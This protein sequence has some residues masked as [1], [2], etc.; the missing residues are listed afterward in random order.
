MAKKMRTMMMAYMTLT[1]SALMLVGGSYALFTDEVNEGVHLQAGTLD[2]GLKRTSLTTYTLDPTTGKTLKTEKTNE[3][4]FTNST[5]NVFGLTADTK[6]VPG[7]TFEATMKLE[8]VDA[9]A[10][11]YWISIELAEKDANGTAIDYGTLHLDDQ[12]A[13]TV[14]VSDEYKIEGR[15]LGNG[16]FTLGS[17][18]DTIGTIEKDGSQTFTVKVEFL[19][20]GDG[21]NNSSMGETIDFDLVVYAVQNTEILETSSSNVNA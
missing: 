20:L 7:N 21:E 5:E 16:S 10:F 15:R 17:A 3:V 9:V 4:D 6:I 13:V 2:A 19:S 1:L 11:D 18:E 8:N 14:Y 12:L